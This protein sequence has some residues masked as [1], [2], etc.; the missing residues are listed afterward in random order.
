MLAGRCAALIRA[1]R[2]LLPD[3]GRSTNSI[4]KLLGVSPGTL[5]NHIP[6]LRELRAGA[7]PRQPEAPT[8]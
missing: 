1:A 2:D 7:V 4:A 5:H 6:D 8:K 3:P